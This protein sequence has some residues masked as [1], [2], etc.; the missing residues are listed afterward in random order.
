[1]NVIIVLL[2]NLAVLLCGEFYYKCIM[3]VEWSGIEWWV[4]KLQILYVI[5]VYSILY[6]RMYFNGTYYY[7]TSFP[8]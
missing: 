2:E 5:Q 7:I 3:V 4:C 6:I 8:P 1:M